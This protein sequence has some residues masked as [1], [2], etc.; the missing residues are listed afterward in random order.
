M[1]YSRTE[2]MQNVIGGVRPSETSLRLDY[3]VDK[4]GSES[5]V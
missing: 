3:I 2:L 1:Q 5:S 4:V